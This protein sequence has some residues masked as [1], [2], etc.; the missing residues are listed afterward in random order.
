MQERSTHRPPDLDLK[1]AHLSSYGPPDLHLGSRPRPPL[2]PRTPAPGT[3]TA[4][5]LARKQRP[6]GSSRQAPGPFSAR[7]PSDPGARSRTPAA[8]AALCVV[9]QARPLRRPQSPLPN[10]PGFLP[11]PRASVSPRCHHHIVDDQV[12]RGQRPRAFLLPRAAGFAGSGPAPGAPIPPGRCSCRHCR[13]VKC[14]EHALL[15]RAPPA[16]PSTARGR[17]EGRGRRG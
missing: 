14:Q 16:G 1:P 17:W 12:R 5:E 13:H 4:W 8:G 10:P 11:P 3:S 9:G 6:E 15:A 2:E 7:L